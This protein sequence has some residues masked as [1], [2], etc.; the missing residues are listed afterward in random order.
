M[1]HFCLF[2]PEFAELESH[3]F[4]HLEIVNELSMLYRIEGTEKSLKP[5][6]L[7][8]HIDV[9]PANGVDDNWTFDPF[10]AEIHD[11]HIY[12][13]GT[14][15]DKQCMVSI[16]EAV[17]LYLRKNPQPKRTFYLA[18]G[19]DEEIS[20]Y[21]GAFKMAEMLK[22]VEFEYVVDEGTLVI[23]NVLSSVK[24]PMAAIGIADK[25]YLTVKY[26]VNVTG[27]HSSMPNAANSALFIIANALN[28]YLALFGHPS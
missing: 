20:G 5:Y 10:G 9:V 27:G 18:F 22:G 1:V 4:V 13:R 8:A 3:K 12:A 7:A 16:L 2:W 24:K 14:M 23:D 15:D 6:L 28:R 11:G 26:F 25:G 21:N 17:T 19:H